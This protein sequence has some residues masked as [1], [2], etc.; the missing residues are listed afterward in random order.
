[1]RDIAEK[2]IIWLV[3]GVIFV[4]LGMWGLNRYERYEC[5]KWSEEAKEFDGYYFT[6]WQL[7]QCRAHDIKL[8]L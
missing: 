8:I 1:M 7:A 6:S 2:A 4:G 5:G 3:I